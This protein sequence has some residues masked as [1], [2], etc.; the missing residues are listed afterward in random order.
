MVTSDQTKGAGVSV[1][2][3]IQP[4][5]GAGG[6]LNASSHSKKALDDLFDKD[7]FEVQSQLVL[8]FT[9]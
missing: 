6:L 1:K 4:F 5:R 2:A 8:V 7:T 3:G 9:F